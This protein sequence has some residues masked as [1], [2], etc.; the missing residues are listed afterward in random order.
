MHGGSDILRQ[1]ELK[2]AL[3]AVQQQL[4]EGLSSVKRQQNALK[5]ELSSVKQQLKDDH[6]PDML[7]QNEF[8]DE[9]SAVPQQLREGLSSVKRQQ[10]TLAGELSSLKQQLQRNHSSVMRHITDLAGSH[11]HT[12]LARWGGKTLIG[13]MLICRYATRVTIKAGRDPIF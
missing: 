7:R 3:G 10:I 6:T 12:P 8:K 5:G 11:A 9:L 1:N 2:D 13:T 4:S